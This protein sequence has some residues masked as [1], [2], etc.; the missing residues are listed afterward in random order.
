MYGQ[1]QAYSMQY[2]GEQYGMDNLRQ[3]A[4]RP[5]LLRDLGRISQ[6]AQIARIW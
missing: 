2:W 4:I 6:R 1:S 3:W 5:D